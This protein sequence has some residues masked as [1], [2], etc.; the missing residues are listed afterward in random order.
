MSYPAIAIKF[1]EG[2]KTMT[3]RVWN[4]TQK[5]TFPV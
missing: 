1:E 3:H 2:I 4:M 5:L